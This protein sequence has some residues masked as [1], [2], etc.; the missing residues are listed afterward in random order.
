MA[1]FQRGFV[2]PAFSPG[3]QPVPAPPVYVIPVGQPQHGPPP[4]YGGPPP[5]HGP[6]PGYGGPPPAY[7]GPPPGRGGSRVAPSNVWPEPAKPRKACS[8]CAVVTIVLVIVLVIIAA[9]GAALGVLLANNAA[10]PV[11]TH[12]YQGSLRITSRAYTPD[13]ANSGSAAFRELAAEVEAGLDAQYRSSDQG[14]TY[15]SSTVTEFSPGSVVASYVVRFVSSSAPSVQ[16]VGDVL[17]DVAYLGLLDLDPTFT[18]TTAVEGCSSDQYQCVFDGSCIPTFAVCD[19]FSDCPILYDQADD[20]LNC[21]CLDW[22]FECDDGSCIFSNWQCDG[23]N[24]CSSGSDEY[25]CHL[26]CGPDDFTCTDGTCIFGSWRCDAY[27]DCADGSDEANCDS[28]DCDAYYTPCADQTQCI[29]TQWLCDGDNDCNDASD[30][31]NCGDILTCEEQ[32]LWECTD[33]R[34]ISPHWLCDGDNDC[35]G[36]EDEAGCEETNRTCDGAQFTCSD[37]GCIPISWLCDAYNDC[38]GGEDEENCAARTCS[39]MEHQCD[40]GACIPISWVCD[41]EPDCPDG[42]DE[43]VDCVA[44]TAEPVPGVEDTN[45]DILEDNCEGTMK[46]C[47]DSAGTCI[48]ALA[49]C[50]GVPDCP[51]EA[52]ELFC[53]CGE[54]PVVDGGGRKKRA[55]PRI[56]GGQN[57]ARGEFPSQV[58]LHVSGYGHVCGGS[59]VN[60]KWVVTAAHCV[61]DDPNPRDWTVYLGLHI[62]GETSSRVQ[63]YDVERIIYHD[64]Y[65]YWRTDFDIALMELDGTVEYDEDGY[66]RPVC[67]P[68][69]DNVF[70]SESD[71]TIS[72]WGTM[73]EGGDTATVLQ[74]AEIPLVPRSVCNDAD[75][76]DGR[77]TTRMICAGHDEGGVDSCQGDSGGPLSCE[78]TDGKW[79]LVGVTSWGEGCAR[80]NRPGIYADVNHFR[81]WIFSVIVH[82]TDTD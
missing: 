36:A 30:E 61:V 79:Y 5:Q 15:N 4:A 66:V 78:D 24:D 48:A 63:V 71:C 47:Y 46:F 37:G 57:A 40:S 58:S 25:D 9:L 41:H 13:L 53:G 64:R 69:D 18:T 73:Y 72:G 7:G 45:P 26:T 68:D 54:R 20:E 50:N 35:T 1:L 42:D 82:Y 21:G 8:T 49:W 76:Y 34:C 70:T 81:D 33:G 62:Q 6:P 32:G 12:L 56:V 23:E 80:P 22:Q 11:K 38:N 2:N 74:D 14:D 29:L 43:Q 67:L 60:N 59:L 65:D 44:P 31:Q 3:G 51:N 28:V 10:A 19:G 39:G 55:K 77:I 27:R 16:S 52:D 17:S 75:H